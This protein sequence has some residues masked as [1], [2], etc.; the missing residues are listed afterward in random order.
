MFLETWLTPCFVSTVR[1]DER[2]VTCTVQTVYTRVECFEQISPFYTS[3]SIFY[4]HL[5]Y[6]LLR[7]KFFLKIF[8]L[9]PCAK[10]ISIRYWTIKVKISSWSYKKVYL[11]QLFRRFCAFLQ[12]TPKK[13]RFLAKTASKNLFWPFLTI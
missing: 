3:P 8:T 1:G 4:G 12:K 13:W 9:D 5:S 7:S 10:S 2:F 6:R 11:T